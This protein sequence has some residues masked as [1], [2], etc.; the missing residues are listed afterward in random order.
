MQSNRRVVRMRKNIS[1][2]HCKMEKPI[3]TPEELKSMGMTQEEFDKSLE[4]ENQYI[5][6]WANRV[7]YKIN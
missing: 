3:M 5:N 2:K 1:I 4:E 7:R 6:S